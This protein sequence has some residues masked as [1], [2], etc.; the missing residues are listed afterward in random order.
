MLTVFPVISQNNILFKQDDPENKANV[1]S[2]QKPSWVMQ[3]FFAMHV[4]IAVN[5]THCE[6]N[7][8][9]A[10]ISTKFFNASTFRASGR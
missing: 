3:D 5:S 8:G 2:T 7:K 6:G 1:T 10:Q 9:R 4:K